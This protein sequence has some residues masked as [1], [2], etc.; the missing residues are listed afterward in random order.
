MSPVALP[1]F[2]VLAQLPA[3]RRYANTLTRDQAEAEDLVHDTLVRAYESRQ[4]FR[5]DGDL[6]SW[7]FSILHNTFINSARRRRADTNRIDRA[8]ELIETVAAPDQE[9]TLRLAQ[10]R[11]AF[12]HLPEEQRAALHLVAMEGMSYQEA[13]R[14]LSI[15]VGTL[16]SRLGR[17]R[18]TLRALEG[19]QPAKIV[20]LRVVGGDDD[21]R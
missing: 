10:V 4:S 1:R 20:K 13:A 18:A 17:A 15:P 8:A 11:E 5:E 3:L 16:M 12:L 14:A 19:E 21:V 6:R 7:L 2:D 9:S